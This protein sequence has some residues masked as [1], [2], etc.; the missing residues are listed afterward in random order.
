MNKIKI[1]IYATLIVVS[2]LNSNIKADVKAIYDLAERVTEGTS[3]G[4]IDFK[5]VNDNEDSL[6][7][8]FEIKNDSNNKVLIE[9]NNLSSLSVGLNYFL[10]YFCGIHI[11]WNN[12]TQKLPSEINLPTIPVYR[13]THLKD[14]YYL[15]YCT[16]S[17]SMPFWDENRWMQE[18]D[19][20]ALHGIN[21]SLLLTGNEVVWKNLLKKIGYSE[22]EITNFIPGPAYMA[23][24]QMNNL[25]GWGGPLPNHWF[26]QQ[27]SLQKKIMSR[28]KGLGISPILPG[29]SGMTQRDFQEKTGFK[30]KDTGKWCGFLRPSFLSPEDTVFRQIADLYY[31]EMKKLYGLADYYAIDPFHE[32]GDVSGLNLETVGT[33]IYDAMKRANPDAKWV[34]QSWQRN[35]IKAMIDPI[36]QGDLIILDLYSEKIPK[37]EKIGGYG[38]HDWLYCML[39]NFGGN[40]GMHGRINSLIE[41]L[42]RAQNSEWG[43][44][45]RGIGATPEGIENNPIMYELLFELPWMNESPDIDLWLEKYLTARYGQEVDRNILDAWRALI[46][47]VYNAPND[48]PGEGTVESIICARPSWKPESASTWGHS[49]LFYSPDSTAKAAALFKYSYHK[50]SANKNFIYDYIDINRQANADEANQL[51]HSLARLKEKDEIDSV[52]ILSQSFLDLLL[53]QDELLNIIPETKV[54][55]WIDA[56]TQAAGENVESQKLFRKNAAMLITVWGDSIAA[57]AGGLHDYSHREWGGIIK[58]LYYPRWKA[59]FDYELYGGELPD[60]YKMELEWVNKIVEGN[61]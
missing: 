53:R 40:I 8:W 19:W 41:G 57:N 56:A 12:L 29:Y 18:I 46:N 4:R 26:E 27:E 2:T 16:F 45:L 23:W 39:L 47:T 6:I 1:Y 44:T 60:Y 54:D 5:L 52:K 50:Y 9:G 10:K 30:V 55:L 28:M 25:Q 43:A 15:N 24:W 34:I 48:Y 36:P 61:N 37:W 49:E 59:F 33:E 51:I 20:M 11:S 35:P 31:G 17:Y 13:K 22:E 32:G 21:M 38:G 3:R 14:R 58:E 7:D 42:H